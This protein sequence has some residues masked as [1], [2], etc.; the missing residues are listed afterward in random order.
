MEGRGNGASRPAA[1]ALPAAGSGVFAPARPAPPHQAACCRCG[2]RQRGL[3]GT[4][5]SR[6][7]GGCRGWG[8]GRGERGS[9]APGGE[10][11]VKRP[12]RVGPA[13]L[14]SK[15]GQHRAKKG[16][17]WCRRARAHRR[18]HLLHHHERDARRV[19]RLQA[20]AGLG[21]GVGGGGQGGAAVR[22]P[23]AG[24]SALAVTWPA[25]Q[26]TARPQPTPRPPSQARP[27]P[28]HTQALTP[29]PRPT[30]QMAMY[31]SCSTHRAVTQAL[32]KPP[33]VPP[34]RCQAPQNPSPHRA[35]GHVLLLQHRRKLALVDA[36]PGGRGG[37]EGVEGREEAFSSRTNAE[38]RDV[39]RWR[40]VLRSAAGTLS[41]GGPQR[42]P[43]AC[44]R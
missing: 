24:C 29:P 19:A 21:W 8:R 40:F 36:V 22:E 16:H 15:T 6:G 28:Q 32:E 33:T 14:D 26:A 17:Q 2:P 9:R 27:H 35:D 5:A 41:R 20:L 42:T 44:S 1:R 38:G 4:A 13:A 30:A 37:G 7:A 31:S 11:G 23:S 43:L 39:R 3:S 25:Q 10:A 34:C 12:R 18:P